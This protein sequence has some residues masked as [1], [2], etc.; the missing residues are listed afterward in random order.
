MKMSYPESYDLV[1]GAAWTLNQ[2]VV[3]KYK[4]EE[5][6]SSSIYNQADPYQPVVDF[7]KY[8]E[9]DD[10][11]E[12]EDLVAWVTI[13]TVHIPHSE[14][15]PNTA[16]AGNTFGFF[17]RPY[18][19]FN[20]DPSISSTDGILIRPTAGFAGTVINQYGKSNNTC[21]PKQPEINFKGTYGSY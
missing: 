17:I 7:K 1:N 10:P 11:I 13:G 21:A 5:E 20:E 6:R 8:Y 3:T 16:T 2:L 4:E 9:D 12:N 19:Y 15:L 18:N 14:D